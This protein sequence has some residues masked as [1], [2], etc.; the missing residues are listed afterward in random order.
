[1]S[2][3][4]YIGI[5][6]GIIL[7]GEIGLIGAGHLISTG[8]VNFWLVVLV[9][10]ILSTVNGE[11]F[12]TL[13]RL[14]SKL[15]KSKKFNAGIARAKKLIDKYDAPLLLFFKVC[16]WDKKPDTDRLCIH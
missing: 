10:T 1:M 8:T 16:I 4:I 6:L 9:G 14:S 11:F 13:S 2:L 7:Q 3:T 5:A 15:I 12:F